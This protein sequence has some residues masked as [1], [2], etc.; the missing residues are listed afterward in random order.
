MSLLPT[1]TVRRLL[2]LAWKEVCQLRR[3][4]MTLAMVVG[5]PLIQFLVFAFAINT[6]VRHL[7]L[8]VLDH[9]R[10]PA[11]RDLVHRLEASG[12]FRDAGVVLNETEAEAAL[13]SGRASAVLVIPPG[14]GAARTIGAP[15]PAQL[16]LDASDPLSVS[17]GLSAAGGLA[18]A[19]AREAGQRPVLD[20]NLVT[21]YNPEG[22]TAVYIVP[23]LVGVILSTSLIILAAIGVAREKER[24]TIEALIASPVRPA[25]IIVGKLLPGVVIGYLQMALILSLGWAL[26]GISPLAALPALVVIGGLFIAG[27]LAIGLLISSSVQTQAQAMQMGLMTLLP[28]ILLSG[29]MFPVAAMPAPAQVLAEILP[30]THFLRVV[31]GLLLKNAGILDVMPDS[32]ALTA[33]LA[34]VIIFAARRTTTRL[35]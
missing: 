33:I 26:F 32:L 2:A 6:D 9:D 12:S 3:D 21:R 8:A 18:E 31:R 10:S 23:G 15:S 16:R 7:P 24:G 25:E 27:N 13:A 14:H 17:G 20:L 34:V 30:L 22:R 29:F 19:L 28:N 1:G 11:S 4:R 5:I 35:G